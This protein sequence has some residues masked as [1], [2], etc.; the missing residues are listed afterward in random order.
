MDG[1]LRKL[2]ENSRSAIDNGVYDIQENLS[3]S[4]Q[5]FIKIIKENKHATL[6]T[7]IKFSSPSLGKIKKVSDPVKIRIFY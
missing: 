4:K 1:I 5:D 3:S 7:E 6:I 2:F